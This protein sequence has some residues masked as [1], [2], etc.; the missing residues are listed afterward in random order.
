MA[1]A[2]PGER[3]RIGLAVHPEVG[4]AL[5]AGGNGGGGGANG[6]P[7]IADFGVGVGY[8]VKPRFELELAILKCVDSTREVLD[9]SGKFNDSLPT[10]V[11]TL[12]RLLAHYHS[13]RPGAG[14]VIGIGPA[15]AT[16]GN[17]GT[18]P[19]LDVEGGFELRSRAG[20]Y[21]AVVMQ[22][23]E[24]LMVSRPEVDPSRCITGDCPSRFDPAHPVG[25][26]RF[27]MGFIF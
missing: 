26:Y 3:P 25:G 22:V 23:I 11:G 17:F 14:A 9:P 19:L 4:F 13:A 10:T 5:T 24:P 16:G 20:L 8:E 7:A 18:V 6:T 21:L 1:E 12:W 27:A 15:V 2:E